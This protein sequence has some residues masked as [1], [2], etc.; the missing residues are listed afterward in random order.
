MKKIKLS[1]KNIII[2]VLIIFVAAFLAFNSQHLIGDNSQKTEQQQDEGCKYYSSKLPKCEEFSCDHTFK[3]FKGDNGVK[4]ERTVRRE[5][6]G[7]DEVGEPDENGNRI[8]R[9][10][11]IDD[12]TNEHDTS[13]ECHY[14]EKLLP[15]IMDHA[16]ILFGLKIPDAAKNLKGDEL[17]NLK[18]GYFT[19]S[20]EQKEACEPIGE[21]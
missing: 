13:F 7:W 4:I 10:L 18:M 17:D 11:E 2:I 8:C 6:V 19:R 21:I 9:V 20:A 5:I 3:N 14:N 16:D 12:V 15:T 1:T